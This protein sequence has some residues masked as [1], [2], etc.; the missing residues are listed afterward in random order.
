M[1]ISPSLL[2]LVTIST[3][4][5]TSP[6]GATYLVADINSD[7]RADISDLRILAQHWMDSLCTD[8]N[9]GDVGG[10]AGVNFDDFVA[11]TLNWQ[12]GMPIISEIMA[13]NDSTL[14]TIYYPGGPL[15]YPDWIEIHNISVSATLDL[16][17]WYLTDNDNDLGKW[18]FPAGA[19]IEPG[20]YEIVFASG[21]D[22]LDPCGYYHTNFQ[23]DKFGEYLA[24]VSPD[25]VVAYE[26]KPKYPLQAE[27]VSFGPGVDTT[28]TIDLIEAACA[29]KYI[30]PTDG[31]L[32]TTWT[33]AGFN[34]LGWS[35]GDTGIG[36]ETSPGDAT[37]YSLLIQSDVESLMYNDTANYWDLNDDFSIDNGN[38]NGEWEYGYI[39]TGDDY[40]LLPTPE[41]GFH[42]ASGSSTAGWHH[43]N[44]DNRGNVWKNLGPNPI[45]DWTSRREP[46]E[47]GCGPGYE[48]G[49]T[50]ARWTAP[51]R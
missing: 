5:L 47:M 36:Y 30:V 40:S 41:S 38:P 14:A 48:H 43:N 29:A 8:P 21:E 44:W 9:C 22:I 23:M 6:V 33:S 37:N 32:G 10:G 16:E 3:I 45:D 2:F 42:S 4:L 26:Y 34:D 28:T 15:E 17:G 27:D 25:G 13:S 50:T 24:I 1:T 49:K 19:S 12:K 51:E 31:S 11:L 35:S 39:D 20:G 7:G 18:P 46:Y